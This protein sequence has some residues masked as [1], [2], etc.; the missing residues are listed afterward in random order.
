LVR[1][2][3]E[4]VE[5]DVEA[6]VADEEHIGRHVLAEVEVT[7]RIRPVQERSSSHARQ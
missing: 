7:S 4:S 5:C 6:V 1:D 2:P 3:E